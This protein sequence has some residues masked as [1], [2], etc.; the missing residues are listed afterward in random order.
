MESYPQPPADIRQQA[1]NP[2]T[3]K[4]TQFLS[5]SSEISKFVN[6]KPRQAKVMQLTTNC[7]STAIR[8]GEERKRYDQ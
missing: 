5:D 6:S 1:K 7:E 3:K 8:Q 2:F 4:F